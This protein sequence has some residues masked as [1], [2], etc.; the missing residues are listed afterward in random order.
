MQAS[1]E[2]YDAN[3]DLKVVRYF[4][5]ASVAW[6]IFGMFIGLVLAAQLYW[7]ALNFDSEYFQFGRLRPVH[8]QGVIFGFVVNVLMGTSLYI[9][10]RT[11]QTKLFNRSLSWMVFWGWQLVLLLAVITLPLGYTTTKEY[12]ELEWPIDLLIVLVWVL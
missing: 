7:P 1:T 12:A 11:G 10:Q 5:V 6:S 2:L 3:Y 9:V 4:I 8:T